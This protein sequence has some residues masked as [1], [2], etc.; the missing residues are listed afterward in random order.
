MDLVADRIGRLAERDSVSCLV[1]GGNDIHR[2][3]SED[4]V[5]RYCTVQGG[6]TG[7]QEE[8]RK[9]SSVWYFA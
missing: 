2:R 9:S 7:S 3:R 5:K 6:T 8:G 4:M 1:I